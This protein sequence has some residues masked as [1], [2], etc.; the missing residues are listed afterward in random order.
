[1]ALREPYASGWYP[2]DN[3]NCAGTIEMYLRGVDL[4]SL[5]NPLLGGLVPHAGWPYS[6]STA[7]ITIAALAH[8]APPPEVV[9]VLGAVH[10]LRVSR[11]TVCSYEGWKT[12]VG[13]LYVERHLRQALMDARVVDVNDDAHT[14]EHSI[15]V[16][17]PLL[18]YILPDAQFVPISVPPDASALAF[19][20]QLARIIVADGRR[21]AVLASSDLTHYGEA[22]GYAP[23]GG[24]EG[25]MEWAR[26]NDEGL[27][28]NVT[29]LDPEG[30]LEH[31]VRRQSACGGG[32]LA[33][34]MTAVK[35]LGATQG[36]VLSRTSSHEQ[37]P[38]GDMWVGYASAVF[39]R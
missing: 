5:P 11:P 26:A 34:T 25:G 27:L 18:R 21:I 31:A 29:R 32:A 8:N 39:R 1:V 6:G 14:Y 16:Q 23:G 19:G 33:A 12:P 3:R 9:V 7:A 10:S 36:Q 22:Y 28:D 4:P 30:A 20:D 24:G 15:E 38:D 13:E 2:P 37:R 35:A 17:T